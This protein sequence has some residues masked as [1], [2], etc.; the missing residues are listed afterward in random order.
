MRFGKRPEASQAFCVLRHSPTLK[1]QD[2]STNHSAMMVW[3]S[4]TIQ[5]QVTIFQVWNPFVFDLNS[6]PRRI[7]IHFLLNVQ[8]DGRLVKMRWTFL[9]RLLP[10][11]AVG[12]NFGLQQIAK[13]N[14]WT[15]WTKSTFADLGPRS[16]HRLFLGC[17][18][19]QQSHL[20]RSQQMQ[21]LVALTCRALF[22]RSWTRELSPL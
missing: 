13:T 4:N 20:P 22:S 12:V 7:T 6:C 18:K 16:C 11:Q 15:A 21:F 10:L 8:S 17:P 14:L 1:V 2:A 3:P 5:K 9:G 19:W